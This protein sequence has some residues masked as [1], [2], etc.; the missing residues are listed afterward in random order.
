L[1]SASNPD[2]SAAGCAGTDSTGD[3]NCPARITASSLIC[4]RWLRSDWRLT[5]YPINDTDAVTS[6]PM[7]VRMA[8]SRDVSPL[9]RWKG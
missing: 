4:R 7:K 5:M 3:N 1:V 9:P 6:T 8:A 2:A